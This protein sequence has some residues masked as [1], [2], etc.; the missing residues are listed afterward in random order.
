MARHR[1]LFLVGTSDIGGTERFLTGLVTR[2]DRARFA[3]AICVVGAPGPLAASYASAAQ[4][5]WHLGWHRTNLGRVLVDWQ[6]VLQAWRPDVVTLFG[7][8][9]NLLGRAISGG[10]PV[11]NALRSAGVDEQGRP[12]ARRLDRASFGRVRLCVANSRAALA[13]H[14]EA[15]FPPERFMWIPNGVDAAPYRV[16]VRA[17]VRE[18]F[19]VAPDERLLLTVGNLIPVKNHALLLRVSRALVDRGITHRL[20][21][22]GEGPE[23]PSL[24]RRVREL[25]LASHVQLLGAAPDLV[26]RYAAAD[27]FVLSSRFE[28]MPNAILEACA[29]GL[30]IVTTAVGEAPAMSQRCGLVVPEGDDRAMTAAIAQL[31]DDP[32]R[33]ARLAAEA[34]RTAEQFAWPAVVE[35]YSRVFEGVAAHAAPEDIIRATVV[36]TP[37]IA[38]PAVLEPAL[39]APRRAASLRF[40]PV[41]LRVAFLGLQAPG[42]SPGQRY[43]IE[44]YLP[45]LRRRGIEVRYDWLL[46]R[47]DLR[48]FYGREPAMKKGAIAGKA[49][50]RRLKSVLRARGVDVFLVQ[51]EAFFLG[52]AW[53]EWLASLRAPVVLDF[54]D[55]IWLP[56]VSEANRSC[57]WL[58]NVRKIAQIASLARTVIAGNDYLASWARQHAENV[59]VVP[60]TIDTDWFAP[61]SSRDPRGPVTIGWS[62]SPSTVA[63]LRTLLPVLERLSARYGDRIRIRVMGDPAFIHLPLGIRGEPWSADAELALVREM[64]I[65]VMPLPDDAWTRGKCGLKGLLSMSMGAASVMSPVGV[66]TEIIQPGENGFLPATDDEWFDTLSRLIDDPE[67]R[68]RVGRAG[69]ETVV[70]QYSVTRWE[71]R[72]AQL[73]SE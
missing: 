66:N 28:G 30:P 62:G 56:N 59:H 8:R 32:D 48:V 25:G 6:A 20:W 29:A 61:P 51:R 5:V 26:A 13:S 68:A 11:I 16:P 47:E 19:G 14:L 33:R 3:S 36:P 2:L 21:I 23:R 1:L 39:S 52:N 63:H 7:L 55:A 10:A 50:M 9:A 22:A 60:T 12:L 72:L 65:G 34:R 64:D 54:D 24:E 67:L 43:R 17:Q 42:R 73:L 18:R 71:G 41:S 4:Q 69:R 58:K 35:Q 45:A 31:L 49:A 15:G 44:A 57:A 38:R 27:V 37:A 40:P 53:S 70:D 46:S